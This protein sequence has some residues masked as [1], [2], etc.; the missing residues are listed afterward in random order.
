MSIEVKS[1]DELKS[2]IDSG[3][4]EIV[5]YDKN[6]VK[7]L[8]AVKL[9][10]SWGPVAVAGIIAAVPLVL[11]TG[12]IGA[13][14][15]AAVAPSAGVATSTIVALIVAIGGVIAISLFT[16]WD[17]VELPGGIKMKHKQKT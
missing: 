3:A 16:D 2:A 15:V 1:I 4:V 17:Y 7:K 10:K 11:T 5:S 8:K 12:P 9:A 6:V 13:G 14:L